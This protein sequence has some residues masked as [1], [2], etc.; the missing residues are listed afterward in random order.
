MGIEQTGH[1]FRRQTRQGLHDQQLVAEVQ[2]G[3]RFV[4]NQHPGLGGQRPGDED[5]LQL[6]AADLA[7]ALVPQRPDA[8]LVHDL[9]RRGQVFGVRLGKDPHPAAAAQQHHLQRA[10][11][12][13]H[14]PGLGYI[15]DAAPQ[16]PVGD[17]PDVPPVQRADAGA[18]AEEAHGTAQQR[19]LARA[20]GAQNG[21]Q[22][23][24]IGGEG[25]V[26]E[27]R[28]GIFI[29]EHAVFHRQFH[30]R[31]PPLFRIRKIKNG[32]PMTAVRMETGISAAEALRATVS[33]A[34][35]KHPPSEM[36]AGSSDRWLLP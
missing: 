21:H 4:Q 25:N 33:T 11:G 31:H 23:A 32:A 35:M 19:G 10:V 22:I 28:G 15:G 7:A 27:H 2:V 3:F 1:P 36:D 13:H 6:A 26:I 5:Q 18:P 8:Q 24:G 20:V 16:F 29:G 34:T 12:R 30:S 9:L 14:A 17:G